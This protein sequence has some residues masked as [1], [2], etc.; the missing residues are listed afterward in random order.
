MH[1]FSSS[2]HAIEHP[3]L[4]FFSCLPDYTVFN[5]ERQT[6][7][8]ESRLNLTIH[9]EITVEV[10]HYI[11]HFQINSHSTGDRNMTCIANET[12]VLQFREN[13]VDRRC[14]NYSV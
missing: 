11:L 8:L 13:D 10:S 4:M 1:P 12:S 6:T 9:G 7:N 3:Q 14:I 2:V 5:Q